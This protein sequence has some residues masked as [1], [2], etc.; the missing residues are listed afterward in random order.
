M[1]TH[2]E[3]REMTIDDYGQI[4]DL[5]SRTPGVGLSNADSK[6]SISKF[7]L[8]N[9]GLSSCCINDNKIIGTILCGHDGRRGYIYHVTVDTEYRGAGIASQL[10]LRSLN[11]L[12]LLGIQKCH[13]FV[14]EDNKVGNSF[15]SKAGWVK[16]NDILVYSKSI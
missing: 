6:E 5:W 12:R 4:Y 15:W 3:I 10:V 13:L 14:F 11:E 8:R 9:K 2:D 1:S 16:R 7:L